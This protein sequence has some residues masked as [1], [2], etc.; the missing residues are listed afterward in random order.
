LD[1]HVWEQVHL[2]IYACVGVEAFRVVLSQRRSTPL[3]AA[4]RLSLRERG[5]I[6]NVSTY[7]QHEDIESVTHI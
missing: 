1:W 4:Q 5:T 3:N 6:G 2:L 7:V